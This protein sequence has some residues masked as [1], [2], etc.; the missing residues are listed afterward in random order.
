M[1]GFRWPVKNK[2]KFFEACASKNLEIFFPFI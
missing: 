1:S 2:K